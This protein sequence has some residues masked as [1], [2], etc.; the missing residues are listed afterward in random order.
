ME[1]VRTL[2]AFADPLRLRI[3]AAVAQGELT[4]GEVQEVVDSVQSAVSRNLGLLR[5][6]GFVRG[7]REGTNVYFSLRSDMPG[8][9]RELFRTFRSKLAELPEVKEDEK[10]LR[11]CRQRRLARSRNY[12]ETIA[13]DWE[14]IRKSYFDD[15]VASIAIEKLLPAGLALADVGCGTGSLSFELARFAGRVIGIDTSAPMLRRARA[16]AR[17]NKIDNV[18]FRTGDAMAL[19]LPT[20][21]VDG[22]FCVMVLHFLADPERAVA[23][24][25]RITRPGGCV[26]VVDLIEHTQEWMRAEMAHRWLGFARQAVESWFRRAGVDAID[27]ELTGAFAGERLARNGKRPVELFVARAVMP[28][29]KLAA[30]GAGARRR[31]NGAR[32]RTSP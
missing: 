18:V 17:Q 12:F 3:L 31:G 5:E 4:V 28:S 15:R 9:A 7:R 19:P 10:R 27:Y 25:C 22:A 2:K 21:S 23:E 13:G 32:R 1:L 11:Q 14:R 6:A 30:S 26:I 8:P 29:G 20:D 16:I 24:L